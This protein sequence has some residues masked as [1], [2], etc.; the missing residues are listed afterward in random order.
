MEKLPA[1]RLE[2][3]MTRDIISCSSDKSLADAYEK[4]AG[5]LIRHIP[6]VDDKGCVVGVFTDHDLDHAYAP[7]E[8][9][10]GWYYDKRELELLSLAHFMTKDPYTLSPDNTLKEAADIMARN[11]FGCIPIATG[12]EK[13]LVGIVTYVDALK[14]LVAL[15]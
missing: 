9:E 6:V 7:R 14:Q 8:T 11:K 13:K 2:K 10:S 4:M 15:F 1:I 12:P 3:F 5:H